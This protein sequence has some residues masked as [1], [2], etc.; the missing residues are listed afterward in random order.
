MNKLNGYQDL[1][2]GS[3]D[4]FASLEGRVRPIDLQQSSNDSIGNTSRYSC[5]NQMIANGFAFGA[6][7]FDRRFGM[8]S[9]LPAIGSKHERFLER[10]L[11]LARIPALLTGLAWYVTHGS[12]RR[13]GE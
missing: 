7:F 12:Q 2:V 8:T 10:N 13:K 3:D 9:S 1:D 4:Y 6:A 11:N 5:W